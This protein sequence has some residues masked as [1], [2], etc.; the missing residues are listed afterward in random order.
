MFHFSTENPLIHVIVVGGN[1]KFDSSRSA[2]ITPVPNVDWGVRIPRY[3]QPKVAE[4]HFAEQKSEHSQMLKSPPRS[5]PLSCS[6]DNYAAS[7]PMP[8]NR[9]KIIDQASAQK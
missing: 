9:E 2:G 4:Q 3:F 5:H 1:I 6:F 8:E 7:S